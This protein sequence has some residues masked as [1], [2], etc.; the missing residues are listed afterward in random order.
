M[1][2]HVLVHTHVHANSVESF[3]LFNT[4]SHTRLASFSYKYC[5]AISI[6]KAGF[7]F[8]TALTQSEASQVWGRL[9]STHTHARVKSN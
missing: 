8:I 5:Y 7:V 1:R 9:I 4:T 6:K 3:T 2:A